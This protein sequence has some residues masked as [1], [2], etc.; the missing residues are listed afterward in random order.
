MQIFELISIS[1]PTPLNELKDE[2]IAELQKALSI[3]G[4]PIGVIDG[5]LGSKTRNAWS[6]F[7][8]DIFSGNPELIGQELI[9]FLQSILNK[10]E[11]RSGKD[12]TTKIGTIKA[13]KEE[14]HAQNIRLNT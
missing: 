13:I 11:S 2:Q 3:L 1:N 14:C 5:L 6:E 7:K 12:F 10:I 9:K 8:T 4:Y